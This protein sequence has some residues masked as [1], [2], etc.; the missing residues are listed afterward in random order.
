MTEKVYIVGVGSTAL[1]RFPDKSV[2]DLTREAVT[3]ALTDAGLELGD[4]EA[5]RFSNTRQGMMENQNTI[6]G[7]CALRSNGV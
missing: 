5:A 7:Q 1:G 4:I 3:A 2:K 6:R